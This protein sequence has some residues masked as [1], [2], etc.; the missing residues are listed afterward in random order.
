L[1]LFEKAGLGAPYAGPRPAGARA[2]AWR[3][4][5]RPRGGAGPRAGGRPG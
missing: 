4:K 5:D 3:E 2:A 1:A